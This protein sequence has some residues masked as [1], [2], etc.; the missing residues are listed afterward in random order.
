KIADRTT[1]GR[2]LCAL[3]GEWTSKAPYAYKKK[4][5]DVERHKRG[6]LVL[7]DKEEI[8]IVRWIFKQ[9]TET[10][11]SCRAL[12]AELNR[13]GVKTRKGDRWS[14]SAVLKML[15]RPAYKGEA[16]YNQTTRA[17]FR[18][19][20]DGK[21]SQAPGKSQVKPS[22][23]W[24]VVECPVIVSKEVWEAGQRKLKR[25]S[26]RRTPLVGGGEFLLSGLLH[27]ANCG[28]VMHGRTY[29]LRSGAKSRRMYYCPSNGKY[30]H[31][32]CGQNSVREA[33]LLAYL[34]GV[35]QEKV[36]SPE[37]LEDA[38]REAKRQL[39]QKN[40]PVPDE[41]KRL[42]RRLRE[43][44]QDIRDGVGELTRVDDDLHGLVMER[45][46]TLRTERDQ[47]AANLEEAECRA[48]R[49]QS[50]AEQDVERVIG[51]LNRLRENITSATP[52]VAREALQRCIE[53]VDLS[54]ESKPKP[55]SKT[56]F[57]RGT[58]FF[59]KQ[60]DLI[61]SVARQPARRRVVT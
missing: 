47:V 44:D 12:A 1:Q 58:C 28:H 45:V 49:P 20:L 35:I 3:R 9:Y 50:D 61:P 32:Q 60:A 53:R 25:R 38:R 36:L 43:L 21:V 11:T 37:G 52:A 33:D 27:C 55:H 4:Y 59:H 34:V 8:R 24:I 14:F 6:Y 15:R 56:R 57:L 26:V 2:Y 46:R 39:G 13:T 48:Q 54:F 29:E 31:G 10:D 42:R 41:T 16:V 30:G 23:D 22:D 51:G 19:I 7:G 40:N 5:K 17:Q 18:T